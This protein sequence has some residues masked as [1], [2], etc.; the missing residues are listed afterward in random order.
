MTAVRTPS[1]GTSP[2]TVTVSVVSRPASGSSVGCADLEFHEGRLARCSRDAKG[3][4]P[5]VG[6][7]DRLF[8]RLRRAVLPELQLRRPDR[9]L[10]PHDDFEGDRDAIAAWGSS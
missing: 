2:A 5:H 1:L 6:D 10:P 9:H 4:G 8:R 3:R 7:H